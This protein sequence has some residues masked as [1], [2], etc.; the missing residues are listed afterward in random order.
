MSSLS[1]HQQEGFLDPK[2][3]VW[4]IPVLPGEHKIVGPD[5]HLGS[6]AIQ[7][8]LGS[9]V[10]ACIRDT[11]NGFGGLNHFLLP[12]DSGAQSGMASSR[13]GVHAMEL[14]INSMLKSGSLKSNL[15]AKVFG[16]A[17]V[18]KNVT[19]DSI[20]EK[21]AQFV[22]DYLNA[23]NIPVAAADLGGS[24]ARKVFYF[25]LTGRVLVQNLTQAV[26]KNAFE[27]ERSY[28]R[29]LPEKPV[30]GPIDLF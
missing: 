26:G 2:L 4:I 21:N 3:Q 23:E 19:G 28:Q 1:P 8:L 6:V 16:G 10:A 20:G 22:M 30:A 17:N 7:T 5:T 18:L 14:L 29:K 15:E 13:Y 12:S 25:P 27:L 9:C 11:E 24:R